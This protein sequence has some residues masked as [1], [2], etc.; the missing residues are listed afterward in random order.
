MILTLT[1][2]PTPNLNRKRKLNYPLVLGDMVDEIKRII[3][4]RFLLMRGSDPDKTQHKA[5][6]FS[7][8]HKMLASVERANHC[9]A[10]RKPTKKQ[11]Q[12]DRMERKVKRLSQNTVLRRQLKRTEKRVNELEEQNYSDLGLPEDDGTDQEMEVTF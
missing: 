11:R 6:F 7:G 1:P 5:D 2:P 12:S 9:G 10:P 3:E 4:L 8:L